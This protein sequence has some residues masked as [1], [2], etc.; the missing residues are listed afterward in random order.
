MRSLIGCTYKCAD[1]GRGQEMNGRLLPGVR[2]GSLGGF[3]RKGRGH[4]GHFSGP[5]LRGRLGD[6]KRRAGRMP[7]VPR[8]GKSGAKRTRAWRSQAFAVPILLRLLAQ[9]E[10]YAPEK[11]KA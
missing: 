6:L 2:G 9:G 4:K 11:R 10:A 5:R 3:G 7:F 1:A 8:A